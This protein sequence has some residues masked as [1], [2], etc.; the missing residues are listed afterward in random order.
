M[1]F[2]WVYG[3]DMVVL[4]HVTMILV[5]GCAEFGNWFGLRFHKTKTTTND[6]CTI[7]AAFLGLLALPVSFSFAMAESRYEKRHD[8]VLEEANAISSAANFALMLPEAAQEPI[9]KLLREYAVQPLV[10]AVQGIPQ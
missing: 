1:I 9:L 4:Y 2:E 8:L 6:L 3:L 5:A 7:V 10:D